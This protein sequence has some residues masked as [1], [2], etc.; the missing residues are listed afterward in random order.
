MIVSQPFVNTTRPVWSLVNC[1]HEYVNFCV[2][3]ISALCPFWYSKGLGFTI[4]P[5]QDNDGKPDTLLE[6]MGGTLTS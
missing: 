4:T 5:D 6:K 3:N 2:T 1:L